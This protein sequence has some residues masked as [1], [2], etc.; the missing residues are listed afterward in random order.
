MDEPT[1]LK[2][3][4]KNKKILRLGGLVLA[5]LILIAILF[6]TFM[7]PSTQPPP[8]SARV[9]A[10][11]SLNDK[12]LPVISDY[13]AEK[14]RA[15]KKALLKQAETLAKER[16]EQ[17]LRLIK[18]DPAAASQVLLPSAV[19]S[20]FPSSVSKHVE[21]AITLTGQLVT[22]LSEA[23][24]GDD[25]HGGKENHYDFYVET[26]QG[27][28]LLHQPKKDTSLVKKTKSQVRVSGI[29]LNTHM[30]LS[31]S[32]SVETTAAVTSTQNV[33]GPKKVAALLINFSNTSGSQ[34]QPMTPDQ[35]RTVMFTDKFSVNNYYQ[36]ATFGKMSLTGKTRPDGDVFGW[37][38]INYSNVGCDYDLWRTAA[39]AK[40][41]S[42][43]IDLSGYDNIV[44]IFPYTS[45]CG[46]DGLAELSG[47]NVWING[48]G[49]ARLH[50]ITHELGHNYGLAHASA[51]NCT[52]GGKVVTISGTCTGDEYGDFYDPMGNLGFYHFNV[53]NKGRLG[54]LN[55]SNTQTVTTN[56]TYTIAPLEKATSG[57]MALRIPRGS[58]F[59]YLETR[60]STDAYDFFS[61]GDSVVNGVSMRIASDYSEAS[62][63]YLVDATP[64]STSLT[65][66]ALP[67]GQTFTD[68]VRGISVKV[69]NVTAAGVTVEVNFSTPPVDT[70]PP[71]QPTN[72]SG[73]TG[74]GS[75]IIPYVQLIWDGS[76]DA[77][78]L[79][80]YDIYRDGALFS[81]SKGWLWIENSV[82]YN[83]THKYYVVA[84]DAAGNKS[85][86]SNTVT[87]TTPS[88]DTQPPTTP[89]ALKAQ[90]PSSSQVNLTW[91]AS[92]DNLRVNGYYIYRNGTQ[93][94][95]SGSASFGDATVTPGVTYTYTVAAFDFSKN[96]SAQ[97]APVS[98]QPGS[99]SGGS[100]GGTTTPPPPPPPP[101]STGGISGKVY[102]AKTNAPV[103]G[104]RITLA[105]G[106]SVQQSTTTD[107]FG[108]YALSQLLP[109]NYQMQVTASPYRHGKKVNVKVISG[110]IIVI[111]VDLR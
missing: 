31:S 59:Y 8:V 89:T 66:K 110:K 78:G 41:Q 94:A 90:S 15:Q 7:Q 25:N 56:G 67:V 99:G 109:D 20:Q 92:T 85:L 61:A 73:S 63:T 24:P 111:D 91:Q 98:I 105:R 32:S 9:S 53:F 43:G 60:A 47:K 104:A 39:Q 80:G 30:A 45:S 26:A 64:S 65:E 16:E 21:T 101:V 93:I 100:G 79:A 70:T 18:E 2:K 57:V 97:S 27:R 11:K 1:G 42:S 12:L 17:V 6:A 82:P 40:A 68:T 77:F 28:V 87:V 84:K 29:K 46:W 74:I 108:G 54:A 55:A 95:V 34:T 72:L 22:I 19:S 50:P 96:T 33:P 48:A 23:K 37:L 88:V 14:D 38:T 102:D 44:M 86:P 107:S 75:N 69:L 3:S 83:T 52:D 13:N 36:T 35:A 58:S 71:T 76:T 5:G 62:T 51:L 49:N 4:V 103:S 10:V 106:S 81:S